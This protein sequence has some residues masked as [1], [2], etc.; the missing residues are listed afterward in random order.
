MLM[1][2]DRRNK[3]KKKLQYFGSIIRAGWLVGGNFKIIP[4][5]EQS[6]QYTIYD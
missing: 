4:I 2:G 1:I 3:S 5:T 6:I